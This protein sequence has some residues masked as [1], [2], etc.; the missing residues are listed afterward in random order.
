MFTLYT[1]PLSANGRKVLAVSRH[2]GLDPEIKLVN[3]YA[4]EGRA[5]EYLA[6]HPLGKIPALVEGD[7]TL[8]ESNAILTYLAEAHGDYRLWSRD[9][10]RRADIARW[11]HWESSHWQPACA[12]VLAPF[13]G[14]RLFPQTAT[15]A[16]IEVPWG[17]A[18]FVSAAT[19]L[20]A[21]LGGRAFITGDALSLA[22]FSIAGMMMYVRGARFP[23]DAYANI[24]AWYARIERVEAWGSTASGPWV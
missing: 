8:W 10:K 18:R 7:L 15:H 11:L 9:P 20:D 22:D 21:Q 19:L 4:G 12:E 13:V 17:N 23:A 6:I 2:L 3:V 5:P 14:S 16:P 24:A 1:T